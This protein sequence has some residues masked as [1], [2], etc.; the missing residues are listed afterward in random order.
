MLTPVLPEGKHVRPGDRADTE[1]PMKAQ[2]RPTVPTSVVWT[3][4]THKNPQPK[5]TPRAISFHALPR[6]AVQTGIGRVGGLVVSMDR[7]SE[8]PPAGP[9]KETPSTG[10]R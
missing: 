9:H 5:E 2:R 6:E 1:D 4:N 7:L 10:K 8:P 3:C